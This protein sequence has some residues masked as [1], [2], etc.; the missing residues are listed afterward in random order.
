ML[1]S[2]ERVHLSIQVSC[3]AC[4]RRFDRVGLSLSWRGVGGGIGTGSAI[5]GSGIGTV[6]IGSGVGAFVGSGT[7][8]VVGSGIG[9]VVAEKRGVGRGVGAVVGTGIGRGVGAA[10]AR[11]LRVA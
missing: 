4:R 10:S 9:V 7:G 8:T 6:V 1:S 3:H 5:V 2:H 11:V